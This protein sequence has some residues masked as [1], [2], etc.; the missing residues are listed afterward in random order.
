VRTQ[1][2]YA[3]SKN[4]NEMVDFGLPVWIG[5]EGDRLKNI[6]LGA[7]G[8]GGVF[9]AYQVMELLVFRICRNEIFIGSFLAGAHLVSSHSARRHGWLK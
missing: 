9:L 2:D 6:E 8:C 1:L 7:F 4:F 5:G 3:P